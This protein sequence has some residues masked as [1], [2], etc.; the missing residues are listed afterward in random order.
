MESSSMNGILTV[1]LLFCLFAIAFYVFYGYC[2]MLL[3]RKT[4]TQNGWMAFVPLLNIYLMTKIGKRNG[5][6]MLF[7]FIPLVSFIW[8][9]FLLNS[10]SKRCGKGALMTL[11]LVLLFPFVFPYLAFSY[12][13]ES[14][15]SGTKNKPINI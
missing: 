8:S 3:A 2:L 12:P 7:I 13:Q 10:I 5:W 4:N 1:F 15:K 6:E 14:G 11:G 9:I